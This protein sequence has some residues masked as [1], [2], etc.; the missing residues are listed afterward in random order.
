MSPDLERCLADLE[1]RIDEAAEQDLLDRWNEFMEGGCPT[2][3]FEPRRRN[4]ASPRTEWPKVS[5]N[6]SLVDFNLM[7]LQQYSICSGL[8]ASG[9]GRLMNVRA[10]Y[11][12]SIL[13][14]V[15]GVKLMVMEG[16]ANTL[17]T[18]WPLDG[19]KAAIRKLVK[20]RTPGSFEGLAGKALEMGN[21][22]VEIGKRYPKIGKYVHIYHPDTQG[23]MDVC[24]ILWGSSLFVDVVDEPS[25]VKEF[26][27]LLTDLYVA[28]LREWYAL[29]PPEWPDKSVHYGCLHKGRVM[30]RDD[31]AV[32]FSPA[33]YR[34]FIFPYDQRVF[35]EFGGGAI[36]FCGRADHFI[37]PLSEMKGLSAVQLS[38]PRLNDMEKVYRRTVDRGRNLLLFDRKTAEDALKR[39]RK[40]RG[41]AH[42]GEM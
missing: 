8:L 19:G 33:M 14:S 37:E 1:T 23:P 16:A 28:F 26:T 40:L 25:L 3:I 24:E 20:R 18:S 36:H 21:R 2:E 31:S 41:R 15:F 42:I 5:V 32:N 34:E 27:S 11:G 38:Q 4:P 30:L 9:D 6:E 13:P 7:A 22:F 39:G 29:V 10:N 35:D 17:P 12:T